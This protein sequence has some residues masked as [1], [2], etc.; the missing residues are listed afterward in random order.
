M[1]WSLRVSLG[2][3]A[4]VAALAAFLWRRAWRND[5]WFA[6]LLLF[7][8]QVQ[9]LEAVLWLDQGCSGP[10]QAATWVLLGWVSLEPLA[11]SLIA[12]ACT[13]RKARSAA[14]WVLAA[15]AA[16]FAAAFAAAAAG[17]PGAA[18]QGWCSRPCGAADCGAHL[19]WSWV[20]NINA[21]WHLAF[22][23]FLATPLAFMRPW[24][25]A[26]A[27]AAYA[28]ATFAAAHV[29]FNPAEVFESM[30]C[31]LAVGGFAVPLVLG[32]PPAKHVRA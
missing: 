14:Q 26:I 31:W 11:H 3:W 17:P 9:A 28:F 32:R 12:L 10:N 20:P 16:A 27:A 21:A 25:H 4:L 1:C 15:A 18:R 29:V 23:A 22:L 19:R 24:S 6:A 8:G 30:W 7:V 2:S 13:P 5:R